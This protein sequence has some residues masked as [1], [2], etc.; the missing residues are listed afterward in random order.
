MHH[1]LQED[2]ADPIIPQCK[3]S[4]SAA[5]Q[6]RKI[7]ESKNSR[8]RLEADLSSINPSMNNSNYENF[9]KVYNNNYSNYSFKVEINS[10]DYESI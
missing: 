1:T 8:G 2:E 6:M 10:V 9:N 3:Y 4:D 5:N 7:I